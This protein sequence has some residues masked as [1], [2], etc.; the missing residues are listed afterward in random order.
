MKKLRLIICI[1]IVCLWTG[2]GMEEYFSQAVMETPGDEKILTLELL[3]DDMEP[4]QEGTPPPTPKPVGEFD[5]PAQWT[6]A[7]EQLDEPSKSWYRVINASL[8]SMEDVPVVLSEEGLA[9][10][11]TEADIDRIFQCVLLDHPEYFFVTGYQYTKY[12]RGDELVSIEF[13]GTYAMD[14][15]TALVRKEEIEES[16]LAILAGIP[17]EASDYEKVRYVYEIIIKN[18]EYSMD[19]PDNQNIYIPYLG[20]ELPYVRDMQRPPSFF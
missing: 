15:E 13:I 8:L 19:A 4:V 12:T 1:L 20:E 6:Y 10:G 18:T 5:D 2:C 3:E 14:R 16:A 7:Y 9:G 11:L 17:S